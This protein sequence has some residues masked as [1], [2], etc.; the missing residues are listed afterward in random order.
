MSDASFP[1]SLQRI[2]WIAHCVRAMALIAM[3]V[4]V[5]FHAIF[6]ADRG[7]V[8]RTAR[9]DWCLDCPMQFDAV[10]RAWGLAV[11]LPQALLTLFALLCLW[12]LFGAYLRGEVFTDGATRHLRRLGQS[13]TAMALVMPLTDTVTILALT[14]G[15]PPGQRMLSVHL[16]SQHYVVLLLGLVLI[17]M[18]MVM[19]EAQRM[20]QENAEFV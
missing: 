8:E 15:N 18:A 11:N 7:L 9:K 17:A 5:G 2:R 19:R 3:A 10:S 6:W 13:V 1:A 16:G 20:A 12:R 4:V 14:L